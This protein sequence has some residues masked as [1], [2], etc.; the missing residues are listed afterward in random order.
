MDAP[1]TY[2]VYNSSVSFS[3]NRDV[4]E[5]PLMKLKKLKWKSGSWY[6]N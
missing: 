6:A 3:Y 2:A 1:G 4:I 5:T